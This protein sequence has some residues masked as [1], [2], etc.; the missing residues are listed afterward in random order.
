MGAHA[1]GHYGYFS[2]T[3][4]ERLADL[5]ARAPRSGGRCRLVHPRR[6]RRDPHPRRRRFRGARAPAASGHRLLRHHGP[7]GGG[8][9]PRGH[10]RLPRAHRPRRDAALQPPALRAGCWPIAAPAGALEPLPAAAPACWCRRRN[11]VVTIRGGVAEGP[12]A[13]GNLTLLQCLIGTPYF[14]DLDGALLFLED[15]N[16]DLYRID[17]MLAHLRM[18]G[19]LSP[20]CAACWSAGSPGSKRHMNDG[21]LGVD[22][23]LDHYFG[24]LGVPGRLRPADRPHRGPVDPAPR[25]ARAVRRGRG[26]G[27]AAG[28]GGRLG[29]AR[30]ARLA[31]RPPHLSLAYGMATPTLTRHRV[32]GVL[33]DILIDV[34][35][36]GRAT[37]RPAVVVVHGFKGFKDWGL[38]PPFAER[39]ARAGCLGRDPQ[40]ERQRGGRHRRVR[41]SRALRPQHLLGRVARPAPGDRRARRRASWA[42]RRP[43]ASGCWAIP[44]RWHR[45]AARRRRPAGAGAGDLGRDLH[46]RALGRRRSVTPGAP[47]AYRS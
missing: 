41:V 7:A 46:R 18:V 26:R 2:G 13:G 31:A 28:A 22:E 8:R 21:A 1:G 23:V 25:R 15:V 36:G 45:R 4:E 34:R 38:W 29:P 16:E 19:A 47:R 33:G 30:I 42:W 11:R 10:G 17:R 20:A 43:P 44:G 24:P 3:D 6:L 9:P 37:P 27:G 32:P 14:P 12:L 40:P 35:A 5:N 39:L